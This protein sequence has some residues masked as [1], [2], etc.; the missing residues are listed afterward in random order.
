MVGVA[1][2]WQT[3]EGCSGRRFHLGDNKEVFD[4]E[5]F[6]IYQAL[7][8]FEEIRQSGEKYTMFSDCQQAI[9]RARLDALG[10][11]QQ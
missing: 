4:A 6:A 8:I 9:R 7:K 10:P 2:A 3:G 5:V 11:G 1:C